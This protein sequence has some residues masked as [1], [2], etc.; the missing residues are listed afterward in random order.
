MEEEEELGEL[1]KEEEDNLWK[2]GNV[3]VR[4]KDR[5]D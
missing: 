3:R 1:E 4:I 2:R 5:G